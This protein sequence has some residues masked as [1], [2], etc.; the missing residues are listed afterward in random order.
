MYY[1][2]CVWVLV[3]SMLSRLSLATMF[4]LSLWALSLY[5]NHHREA[6]FDGT[7]NEYT[8]AGV[9]FGVGYV[10]SGNCADKTFEECQRAAVLYLKQ[11]VVE[12][13]GEGDE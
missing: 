4:A 11:N 10:Y 8:Q 9:S 5:I 12:N 13:T 3:R 6:K 1:L 2:H 7:V